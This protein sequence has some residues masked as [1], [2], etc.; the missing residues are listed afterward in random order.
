MRLRDEIKVMVGIIKGKVQREISKRG[1]ISLGKV[2]YLIKGLR[3][4][5]MIKKTREGYRVTKKGEKKIR[6]IYL[7]YINYLEEEKRKIKRE[8]K[9]VI[10][11]D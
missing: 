10:N 2:N 5:R 1:G 8:V 6:E 9:G 11:I 7:K 4:Q 3:K